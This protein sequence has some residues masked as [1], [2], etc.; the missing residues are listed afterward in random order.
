MSGREAAARGDVRTLREKRRLEMKGRG[1]G[2]GGGSN[3]VK[4]EK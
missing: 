4:V 2:P 1:R 3:G